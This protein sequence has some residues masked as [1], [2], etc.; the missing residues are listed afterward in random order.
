MVQSG[1][2][3]LVWELESLVGGVCPT[4]AVGYVG[5]RS[6]PGNGGGGRVVR[7]PEADHQGHCERT[8]LSRFP[9][10]VSHPDPGVVDGKVVLEHL[11]SESAGGGSR[12]C[13]RLRQEARVGLGSHVSDTPLQ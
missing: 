3:S 10:A 7:L 5:F 1:V 12:H 8:L 9:G 2:P 13:R 4:L 6:L 11:A